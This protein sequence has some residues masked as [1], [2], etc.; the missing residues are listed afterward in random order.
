MSDWMQSSDHSWPYQTV[1]VWHCW[2]LAVAVCHICETQTL[3]LVWASLQGFHQETLH[4]PL[5][6]TSRGVSCLQGRLAPTMH[7]LC[8]IQLLSLSALM[9]SSRISTMLIEVDHNMKFGLWECLVKLIHEG[10]D[11]TTTKCIWQLANCRAELVS[12]VMLP[13]HLIN[14]LKLPHH[15]HGYIQP[16]MPWILVARCQRASYISWCPLTAR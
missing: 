11:L 3:L 9:T 15:A 10:L 4:E 12:A 13:Q 8:R 14:I 1:A 6:L 2:W 5:S 16:V 7:I